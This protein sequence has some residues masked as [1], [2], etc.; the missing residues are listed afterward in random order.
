MNI[1]GQRS[2]TKN[3]ELKSHVTGARKGYNKN[4]LILLTCASNKFRLS[5]NAGDAV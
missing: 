3:N 5:D 1:A 2:E 4:K